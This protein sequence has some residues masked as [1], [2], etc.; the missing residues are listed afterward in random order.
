MGVVFPNRAARE[1]SSLLTLAFSAVLVLGGTAAEP[2]YS[3]VGTFSGTN[4]S[5]ASPNN[6]CQGPGGAIYGTT[7]GGGASHEG[8][9]FRLESA[10]P[11]V[12]ASFSRA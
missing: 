7:Y 8:T 9:L 4:F 1:K 6:L 5:G 10:G 2:Q 12:L 11:T 3:V